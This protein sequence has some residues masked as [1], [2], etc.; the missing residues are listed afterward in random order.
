MA[1]GRSPHART[2]SRARCR[3]RTSLRGASSSRHEGEGPAASRVTTCQGQGREEGRC[4]GVQGFETNWAVVGVTPLLLTLLPPL[5]WPP[6][7]R[8]F[9]GIADGPTS[10]HWHRFI[11]ANASEMES[12]P[13]SRTSRVVSYSQFALKCRGARVRGTKHAPRDATVSSNVTS[14]GDVGVAPSVL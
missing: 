9:D 12:K 8:C 6:R 5:R 4:L 14:H 3:F 10:L 11:A 13:A 7:G 1:S 2:P